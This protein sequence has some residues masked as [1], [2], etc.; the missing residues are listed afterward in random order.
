MIV[1][2]MVLQV[3]QSRGKISIGYLAVPSYERITDLDSICPLERCP[4]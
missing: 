1:V 2:F 4:P 3:S